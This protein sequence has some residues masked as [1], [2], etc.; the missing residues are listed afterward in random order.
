MRLGAPESIESTADVR[1]SPAVLLERIAELTAAVEARDS[2]IAVTAHELRNPMTPMVGQVEL[3]LGGVRSGRLSAPDVERRLERLERAM[4]HFMRRSAV[5]LDVSRINS[6]QFRL[7]PER[8]DIAEV[9]RQVV[10]RFEEA[11][12]HVGSEVSVEAPDALVGNWDCLALE[13][14]AD[15]LVSNAIKYGGPNAVVVC[16]EPVDGKAVLRVRDHGPGISEDDRARIFGRFERAVQPQSHNGFGVGL[17]V[18]GQLVQAMNGTILVDH[19][20]GG[21]AVFTV[22]LPLPPENRFA[23]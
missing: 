1:S 2:F 5:L 23:E 17:W 14:V 6:G 4:R 18:V 21:G 7:Q 22:E 13:Q 11:A 19:A 20:N 12:R 15:N 16:V 3:L 9:I 10:E 8:C